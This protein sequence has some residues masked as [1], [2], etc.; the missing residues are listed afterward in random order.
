MTGQPAPIFRS[1]HITSA[2]CHTVY[3]DSGCDVAPACLRCPL[4]RCKYDDIPQYRNAKIAHRDDAVIAAILDGMPTEEAAA[5]HGLCVGTV[6]RILAR[7]KRTH[8]R[9]HS[10]LL[11]MS[12]RQEVAK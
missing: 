2:N 8:G 6:Y 4:P 10:L 9:P 7:R 3:P 11:P 5:R 12:Y 1:G